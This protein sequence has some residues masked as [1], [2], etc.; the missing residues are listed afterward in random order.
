MASAAKED[1]KLVLQK[2]EMLTVDA[3]SDEMT[4][5]RLGRDDSSC[6]ITPGLRM[7]IRDKTH[8]SRRTA[9]RL[10]LAPGQVMGGNGQPWGLPLTSHYPPGPPTPCLSWL[11]FGNDM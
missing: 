6:G 4:A 7:I 11:R 3:A 2:V 8:A 1:A 10:T 5:G 9:P